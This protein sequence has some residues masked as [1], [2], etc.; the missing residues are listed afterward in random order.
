LLVWPK[1]R[2]REGGG[3]GSG[4]LQTSW[5]GSFSTR[6]KSSMALGQQILVLVH[7]RF[8]QFVPTKTPGLLC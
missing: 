1:V 7:M 5:V 8:F 6:I 4:I 3:D 2:N